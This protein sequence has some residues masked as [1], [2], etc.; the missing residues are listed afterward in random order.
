MF[1][2]AFSY[3]LGDYNMIYNARFIIFQVLAQNW[4]TSKTDTCKT[5]T[6]YFPQGVRFIE[7]SL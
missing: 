1:L 7:V 6:F 2:I 4:K 5:D 3:P